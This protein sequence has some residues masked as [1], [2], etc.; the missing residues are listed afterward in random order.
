MP[1]S[2]TFTIQDNGKFSAKAKWGEKE[3]PK[4]IGKFRKLLKDIQTGIHNL[5]ICEAVIFY[6]D[7]TLDKKTAKKILKPLIQG[8]NEQDL[9]MLFPYEIGKEI[10]DES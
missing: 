4:N 5:D 7:K 6:A 2:I 10:S 8:E 3:T 9:P 1:C